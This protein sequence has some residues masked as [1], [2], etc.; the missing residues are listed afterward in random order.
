MPLGLQLPLTPRTLFGDLMVTEGL[1]HPKLLLSKLTCVLPTPENLRGP[2]RLETLETPKGRGLELPR[3][4]F[5]DLNF[6]SGTH[7][8]MGGRTTHGAS[9]LGPH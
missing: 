8:H 3:T 1:K 7:V 9:T 6:S 5:G 2:E 4:L